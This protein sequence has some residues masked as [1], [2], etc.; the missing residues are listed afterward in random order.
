MHFVAPVR[1]TAARS[2]RLAASPIVIDR[3]MRDVRLQEGFR[4]GAPLPAGFGIGLT[5]RVVEY[6]W[7]AARRPHGNVL[8]AGSTLNHRLVLRRLLP[9]LTTLHIVT[10]APERHAFTRLGVSYVYAD[11]RDLPYADDSF[12]TVICLSTIEHV[13]MDNTRYGAGGAS[14]D[15]RTAAMSAGKELRRVLRD[16]GRLLLTVPF[17]RREEFGWFRVFAANDIDEFVAAVGGAAHTTIYLY[18]RRGWQVASP[19][20]AVDAVYR[21]RGREPYPRDRAAAAR[22]VACIEI[23]LSLLTPRDAGS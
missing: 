22:A 18:G 21:L 7:L 16:S 10:L 5:E 23:D 2:M 8:D 1:E 12:D 13:G 20:D 4:T 11:L 19:A 17:G 14:D 9:D 6:G 3:A 15:A